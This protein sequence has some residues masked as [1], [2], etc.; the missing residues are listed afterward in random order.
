MITIKPISSYYNDDDVAVIA[1][2]AELNAAL[3]CRQSELAEVDAAI[4]SRTEIMPDPEER[5]ESLIAGI[6]VP[7]PQP[8]GVKRTELQY[9]IIDI[10]A[11]LEFMSGKERQV[12]H[13]A[14]I[15]LTKDIR[16]QV[17]LAETELVDALVLA[18]RKHLDYWRGKRHLL[19]HDI[20]L[21]GLFESR[22]DDILGVPLNGQ[23]PLADLFRAAVKSRHLKV[24]PVEL[25]T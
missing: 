7:R 15:R 20:H 2:K 19:N 18:H 23:T 22:V 24:L 25:R 3:T 5:I 9:M 11:A 10:K 6:D 4:A 13:K 1:R 21:C 8:L 16:P 17:D 12:N 14:S